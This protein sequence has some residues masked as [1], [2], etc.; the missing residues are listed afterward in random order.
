MTAWAFAT[1]RSPHDPLFRVLTLESI[2]KITE[3]QSASLSMLAWAFAHLSVNPAIYGSL[4]QSISH[5]ACALIRS[6]GQQV[7]FPLLT[8]CPSERWFVFIALC[9]RR[10]ICQI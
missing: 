8:V 2:R 7:Y 6:F 5:Q 3:F 4:F 9:L 1:L 10:R